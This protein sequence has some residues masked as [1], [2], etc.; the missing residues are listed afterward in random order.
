M[1][2][3]AAMRCRHSPEPPEAERGRK[4]PPWESPG[5]NWALWYLDFCL[6]AS[7]TVRA[8][9]AVVFS[10]PH[11]LCPFVVA[12]TGSWDSILSPDTDRKALDKVVHLPTNSLKRPGEGQAAS[13]QPVERGPG[14]V[15]SP[16]PAQPTQW[17]IIIV[18]TD[19]QERTGCP[20][21]ETGNATGVKM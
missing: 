5:G 13:L 16:Q 4:D 7:R 21:P 12:A 15:V 6:P 10:K 17:L 2:T 20:Q 18:N 9:K 8:H 14:P 19:Y 1:E 11:S 3:E